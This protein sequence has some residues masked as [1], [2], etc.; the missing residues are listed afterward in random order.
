[1]ISFGCFL[2][3]LTERGTD[4]GYGHFPL[5]GN[6]SSVL[7]GL[8]SSGKTRASRRQPV[9]DRLAS[10]TYVSTHATLSHKHATRVIRSALSDTKSDFV[11][12]VRITLANLEPY[13]SPGR[14]VHF[15][16]LIGSWQVCRATFNCFCCCFCLFYE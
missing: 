5:E 16:M 1:M 7:H 13:T 11:T 4:H 10:A 6:G 8:D 3:H 15:L 14:C 9:S 2:P 12:I